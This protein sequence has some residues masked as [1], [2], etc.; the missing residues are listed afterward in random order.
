M[1]D[2]VMA[3]HNLDSIGKYIGMVPYGTAAENLAYL[4]ANI[5][6]GGLNSSTYTGYDTSVDVLFVLQVTNDDI[7]KNTNLN[8]RF[9]AG[10]LTYVKDDEV[11]NTNYYNIGNFY[12]NVSA[13]YHEMG[14]DL[15][16]TQYSNLFNEWLKNEFKLEDI[17]GYDIDSQGRL[18][19]NN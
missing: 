6:I 18:V 14:E 8:S 16:S 3:F 19:N 15:L 12:K 17:T 10:N 9:E 11:F 1:N 2:V 5:A 4:G 13:I 7:T